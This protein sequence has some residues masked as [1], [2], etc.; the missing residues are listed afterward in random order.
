MIQIGTADRDLGTSVSSSF[1]GFIG[2]AVGRT[3]FWNSLVEFRANKITRND[4][5]TQIAAY[6][7]TCVDL[8]ENF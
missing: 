1:R 3:T 2:I 8:F 6:Y 7:R 5:V 4:A